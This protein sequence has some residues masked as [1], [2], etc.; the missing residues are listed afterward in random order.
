MAKRKTVEQKE[1]ESLISKNLN[2]IGRK[3]AV[4][5]ARNS[6][7]SNKQKA[8]LRD[9]INYRVKPFNTLTLSEFNYGK[10]NTPK[11]QPTP[12]DRD[13]IKNTP[14]RIAVKEHVPD[15]I[16]TLIKDLKEMIISPI[17]LKK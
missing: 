16:N 6:K 11:G 1:V 14:I 7:V 2:A 10:Y 17:K 15:G 3:G 12:Q 13:N 5:A 8:H 9:S 4:M